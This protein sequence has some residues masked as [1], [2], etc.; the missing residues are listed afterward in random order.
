MIAADTMPRELLKDRIAKTLTRRI[1]GGIYPV[2]S[3]LPGEMELMKTEGVSRFTIRAA[4]SQLERHGLIKRT[5]HTGTQVISRGSAQGFNQQLG[6]VSDLGRLAEHHRRKLLGVQ[7]TVISRERAA[8]IHCRPGETMIRFTMIR[9]GS[10]EGDLPIAW[11]SEY[12]DRSLQQLVTEA[13]LHP[14]KLMM[15]LITAVYGITCAE[16]RQTIEAAAL[17]A[18]PAHF[19]RAEEGS[20]ALRILRRY[21]NARGDVILTTVSY[22]PGDRYA[23]NL[24][25]RSE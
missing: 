23:F 2:G 22:H 15:E 1:A 3:F 11:T 10:K 7:E 12:V 5:P 20:P 6:S 19:L 17:P 4:L 14:D 8:K 25:V 24:N 21:M 13:P 9:E 16:I 18:E